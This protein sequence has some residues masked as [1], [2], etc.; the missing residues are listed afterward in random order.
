MVTGLRE[1]RYTLLPGLYVLEIQDV[2]GNFEQVMFGVNAGS[3]L[4]SDSAPG[5][6]VRELPGLDETEGESASNH[7]IRGFRDL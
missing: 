1:F 4:E 2:D 5:D 6:W 3:D 7:T